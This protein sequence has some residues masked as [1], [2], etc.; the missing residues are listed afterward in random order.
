MV[1]E[2]VICVLFFFG[3]YR[4]YISFL[5]YYKLRKKNLLKIVIGVEYC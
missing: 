3:L 4:M 1:R 5:V 2:I